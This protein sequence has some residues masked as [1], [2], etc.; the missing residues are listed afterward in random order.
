[1][2]SSH[3]SLSIAFLRSI[4]VIA[5][6]THSL[7]APVD[8]KVATEAGSARL[9]RNGEP[10]FVKGVG[11]DASLEALARAGGNSFRTW[12]DEK[13]DGQLAAAQKLGLTVTAGIWL[14]QVRQGFDWTDA[15]SLERQMA[16][17]RA[18]VEK[19]KDSPALLIW[20]LGNEMED[21][22]GSN[23][24][25]WLAIDSLA[26]MVKQIDPHHPVMT[27]IAEIGG[28]KVQNIHKFCPDID[29]IGINSYAGAPSLPERYQKAGGTKPYIVTE[30]GPPGIWEV[31]KNGIGAYTEPSSTE[32]AEIYRRVYN[33]AIVGSKL[34]LGSYAFLWGQKQEATSTWFSMFLKDGTR[35]APVDAIEDLW[36]GKPP[37]DRCPAI[38]SMKL[39]GAD[40]VDP[41]ATVT[42]TLQA[43]DP[44]NDPMKAE[45]IVQ[46]DA[47]EFGSGGDNEQAPPTFPKAILSAD[48]KGAKIVMP[49]EPGLYRIFAIV[50]DDHGGGA[51]ANEPI[52]VKGDAAPAASRKAALPLIVYDEDGHDLPYAPAGWM[53]DAKAIKLDPACT[54]KPHTG[55]T[56]MRCD[57]TAATGWGGVVWQSPANDWGDRPG[58]FNL[59]GAKKVSFWARGEKGGEVV[60]FKFGVLPRDEPFYDTAQGQTEPVPLTADWKQYSIDAVGK[61]LSRI[62]TAFVWTVA[63]SG[64]PITFY[65][66]DIIW[67]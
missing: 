5:M 22:T 39:E 18:T 12:G 53:G 27:V 51:T 2:A 48:L 30:F 9:L 61:D 23:A 59:T 49:G 42:L 3:S 56:C 66:D 63:A 34:C 4:S 21:P 52:R 20:A 16:H 11:G 57:F 41:G 13:L 25:V 65:L 45:W 17:V 62:K 32:K 6:L 15:A 46:R 55:K 43:T 1:M 60:T 14:G 36:S 64:A 40:T 28:Q 26:R 37:A 54:A 10:Y 67:E 50:R 24:A 35:L 47:G 31:K 29:I 7:A 58:G 38:S 33:S 8:V 19:H 44:E